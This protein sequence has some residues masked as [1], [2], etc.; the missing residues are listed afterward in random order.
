MSESISEMILPGTYI[1]VRS[2]GLI[3]VGSIAT[4]NLGIVGTA[5]RGPRNVAVALGSY[6]DALDAFGTYNAATTVNALSLTRAL[7]LAFTGGA[8]SVYAVRI[9]NGDPIAA[10]IRVNAAGGAGGFT[11]TAVDAGSWGNLVHYSVVNQGTVAAPNFQLS[12][13]YLNVR[14]TFQGATVGEIAAALAASRLVKVTGTVDDPGGQLAIVDD[15]TARLT[16]G[17]DHPDVSSADL[18]D[19]LA[20]LESQPVNILIVAGFGADTAR[21]VVAG[22]LERTE[23]EGHERIA[24]L[25]AKTSAPADVLADSA[26]VA[27][28][29]IVLVAPGVIATD[30]STGRPATLPP[31]YL[32]AVI[33]GELSTLAPHISMTNKQVSV[34]DL[35]VEYNTTV[36]KNLLQNRVLLVREK[37]GFQIV[38]G[39]TTDPGAF[40]QISVRRI[41]DYAKA[42]VRSGADPYIGRLNNSRV[43]GALRATLDAFLSEMVL[44]EML[45]GYELEVSATRAQEIA[46]VAQVTLTLEPTFSI[47]FVRVTM[48]L[49]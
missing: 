39:I 18:A 29:R 28:P 25:G 10:S 3:S 47:D 11:M 30:A 22:H 14:E 46:G 36:A 7:E 33:A 6:S 48:V 5:A 9:A 1:E 31:S 43:R 8:Q 20:A 37:L 19:G 15:P 27:S 13:K 17:N 24:I 45:V 38:K 42:G 49:Q 32:A 35:D 40:S 12:L 34:D 4:G 21:G 2:E 41:V 16:H 44:A 23:N 26:S